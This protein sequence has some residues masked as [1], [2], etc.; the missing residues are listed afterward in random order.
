MEQTRKNNIIL[1]EGNSYYVDET[2]A[3]LREKIN[4]DILINFDGES[5]ELEKISSE[6]SS[7]DIFSKKKFIV[8][9]GVPPKDTD[10]MLPV[11]SKIP[12]DN[13]VIFCSYSPVKSKKKFYEFFN[14]IGKLFSFDFEIGN[15]EK[16]I[17][18]MFD[19][20]KKTASDDVIKDIAL[21][22]GKD[23]K[24]IKN[25]LEK[26]FMYVG[27]RKKI[28][29]EDFKEVCYSNVDFII[30]DLLKY[31]SSRNISKAMD[32]LYVATTSENN[33]EYILSMIVRSIRLSIML[34]DGEQNKI[35]LENN[36]ADI[37]KIKK[38]D[39][40]STFSDYEIKNTFQNSSSF[41]NKFS[42]IELCHCLKNAYDAVLN[43]RK[44]YKKED[45]EK[46]MSLLF[47]KICFPSSFAE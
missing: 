47:F 41:F 2:L 1:I 30:W 14:T 7:E 26:L 3:K 33:Y 38:A 35:G 23:Y 39:G 24:I 27:D 31:L 42:Y 10:K 4:Y 19:N 16:I 5:D 9:H 12:K 45:K 37:K 28:E 6:I 15:P 17:K 13:V 43:V 22:I 46:E 8:I 21:N 40:S 34:K 20:R 18:E 11:L 44:V 36:V 32:S 25:E 29:I